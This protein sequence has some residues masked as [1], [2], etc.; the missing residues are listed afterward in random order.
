MNKVRENRLRRMAKRQGLMLRKSRRRDPRATSYGLW[1]LEP[2]SK[3]RSVPGAC[4]PEADFCYRIE[5][6]ERMLDLGTHSENARG[7]RIL[8]SVLDP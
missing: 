4:W 7:A 5:K 3:G 1:A 6:I 2:H 8:Y